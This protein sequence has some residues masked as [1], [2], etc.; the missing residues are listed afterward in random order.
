MERMEA[1][2]YRV[3]AAATRDLY[4]QRKVSKP[5][6]S[7]LPPDEQGLVDDQVGRDKAAG[8]RRQEQAAPG[9]LGNQAFGRAEAGDFIG[10]V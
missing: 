5:I 1:E 4:R 2:G 6:F 8:Q 9:V 3:M 10:E 7:E